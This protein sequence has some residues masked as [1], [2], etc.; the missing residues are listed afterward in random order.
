MKKK[1]LLAATSTILFLLVLE[2]I[3]RATNSFFDI[4]DVYRRRD[5][6]WQEN[7]VKLNSVGYRDREYSK[8][9]NKD[10]FRIYALGDSYTFGWLIDD[11]GDSYPKILEKELNEKLS[12]RVEVINAA[13][14]GFSISEELSRFRSEGV[15]Y[16]PDLVLLAINDDEALVNNDYSERLDQFLPEFIRKLRIY[17]ATLGSIFN[18]VVEN[19]NHNLLTS[20]YTNKDSKDWSEFSK[21]VLL[22]KEEAEKY[23]VRLG[24]IVYPHI[25]PNKPNNNYDLYP[26]NKKFQEFGRE[27]NIIIIDPVNRFLEYKNKEKLVINPADPHPTTEMNRMIVEEFSQTFDFENC[28][29]NQKT[30]TPQI[31]TVNI[32]SKVNSIWPYKF[33]R[34][35][36]SQNDSN[37]DFPW[38]YY[39]TKNDEFGMQEFPLTDLSFRQTPFFNDRLQ[40]A[41]SLSGIIGADIVYYVKPGKVGQI[42]LP[43]KLYGFPIIGINNALAIYVK[44]GGNRGDYINPSEIAIKENKL[45]INFKPK[46]KYNLFKINLKVGVKKIDIAPTGEIQNMEQTIQLDKM[47]EKESNSIAILTNFKSLGIPEFYNGTEKYPYAFIDDMLTKVEKVDLDETS[48]F[49]TFKKPLKKGQKIKV[50]TG[51]AYKLAND[52]ILE[53]E[54]ER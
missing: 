43:D 35:I 41:K 25:H 37:T 11:P 18:R 34:N 16:Y 54:V 19:K 12:K 14:P 32:T 45:I 42:V 2:I 40:V 9:K 17:N 23:G 36:E 24:I 20:I 10:T 21:Q 53:L 49:L 5:L 33:I 46:R 44:D 15:Q 31:E 13:T 29:L 51:G 48:I 39:E 27:N 26:Y 7:F 22:I 3:F 6:V 50:F 8:D 30:Y 47:L 4:N 28:I 52:Q 1:I 38:I